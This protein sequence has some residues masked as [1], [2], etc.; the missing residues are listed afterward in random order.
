MFGGKRGFSGGRE[1][2]LYPAQREK[3][4]LLPWQEE[5]KETKKDGDETVTME[6]LANT[7][8]PFLAP[9]GRRSM[10]G[11]GGWGKKSLL[12]QEGRSSRNKRA[13]PPMNVIK[14]EDSVPDTVHD[15]KV[16]KI[17]KEPFANA[18]GIS[19]GFSLSKLNHS[20]PDI[21]YRINVSNTFYIF[22]TP[23]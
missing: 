11:Y 3:R 12:V 15:V 17:Q 4:E 20:F 22:I 2:Q 10:V 13:L 8:F 1:A 23:T 21:V 18:L 5:V 16:T 6:L 14:E 9:R 7:L 19:N